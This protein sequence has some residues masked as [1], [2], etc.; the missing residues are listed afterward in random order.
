[1]RLLLGY[2][3]LCGGIGLIFRSPFSG[4]IIVSLYYF[5]R[6]EFWGFPS[7]M[8]FSYVFTYAT[9]I[10]YILHVGLRKETISANSTT[11]I[12]VFF[13]FM[14]YLSSQNALVS[15]EISMAY[16]T[17]IFKL[18]IFMFLISNLISTEKRLNIF[19][20]SL[21]LGTVYVI[22]EAVMLYIISRSLRVDVQ[23]AQQGGANYLAMLIAMTFPFLL[24]KLSSDSSKEK[25]L[26]YIFIPFWL[27]G[28]ILTGSRAGFLAVLVVILLFLARS[29]KKLFKIGLLL[30][31]T[32]IILVITPNEYW[33][34]MRT[35]YYYD[36]D[37][38]ALSRLELWKIAFEYFLRFPL[39]GIG[40]DNFR[41]VNTA[42]TE[43]RNTITGE[44]LV[45]HNTFI[46]IL[47]EG[48]VVNFLLF[49]ALIVNSFRL[50]NIKLYYR[51]NLF[52]GLTTYIDSLRIGLIAFIVYS[53]FG[54]TFHRDIFYWYIGCIAAV[55]YVI[56]QSEK[57]KQE[58]AL[59]NI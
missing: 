7:N 57:V 21:M 10:S 43:Y 25:I 19:M 26:A 23:G 22:K 58:S 52:K 59:V 51:T 8:S 38:S 12:S 39:L 48:G 56:S 15:K 30:V 5:I 54:S 1:M 13:I 3:F 27:W 18:L 50:L 47:V 53:F 4:I 40:L 45:A 33:D 11:C 14:L 20:W 17:N 44:G 29:S 28:L 2:L 46:Q 9:I 49:I 24:F 6:P 55:F 31:F 34:R 35:I 41:L 36:Q 16:F 37:A 32:A 42:L